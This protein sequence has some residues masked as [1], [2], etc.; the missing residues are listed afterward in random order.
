MAEPWKQFV[1]SAQVEF[2]D[3]IRV[4]DSVSDLSYNWAHQD[5][6]PPPTEEEIASLLPVIIP[7]DGKCPVCRD[8]LYCTF[9][10]KIQHG[11]GF[12][13]NCNKVDILRYHYVRDNKIRVI[14]DELVG[15]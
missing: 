4:V 7:V 1:K 10:W 9:E 2:G 13:S 6:E 12:C 3:K 8:P 11:V 5:P 15:F 14:F